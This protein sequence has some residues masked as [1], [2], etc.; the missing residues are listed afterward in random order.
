[1]NHLITFTDGTEIS[2]EEAAQKIEAEGSI[3][4]TEGFGN[5]YG[6]CAGGVLMDWRLPYRIGPQGYIQKPEF[7]RIVEASVGFEGTPE[8][9][10]TV[11]AAWCREQE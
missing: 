1:M 4:Q 3:H 9:R 2:W 8:E 11:M 6:R 10:A 5:E 7:E